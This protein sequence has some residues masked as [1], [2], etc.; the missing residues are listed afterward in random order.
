[1]A[2]SCNIAQQH[3]QAQHLHKKL[4][5]KDDTAVRFYVGDKV[6]LYTPVVS[7][8][9]T[10]ILFHSRKVPTQLLKKLESYQLQDT[11]H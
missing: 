6:W 2:A 7:K 3:L 10:K 1:M 4:H 9:K 5:D 8:G 11:T